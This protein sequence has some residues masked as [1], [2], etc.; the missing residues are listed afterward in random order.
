MLQITTFPSRV[1]YTYYLIFNI[2]VFIYTIMLSLLIL[3]KKT[4]LEFRILRL[5]GRVISLISPF[6]G[7]SFGPV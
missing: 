6:S 1:K 2:Y 4:G 5:E 3:L 7:S